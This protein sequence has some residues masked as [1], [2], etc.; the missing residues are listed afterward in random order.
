MFI[1]EEDPSSLISESSRINGIYFA[2][3]LLKANQAVSEQS[4]Q[5][6]NNRVTL[7][8]PIQQGE[9]RFRQC[10][11]AVGALI[12]FQLQH[13]AGQELKAQVS[14]H[15]VALVDTD[16]IKSILQC[17]DILIKH[18]LLLVVE[19]CHSKYIDHIPQ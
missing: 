12:L 8:Q 15:V 5:L 7:Y 14:N 17:Y 1:V 2:S 6:S 19:I 3:L 9:L 18:E 10:P 16:L 4:M 11:A 13:I